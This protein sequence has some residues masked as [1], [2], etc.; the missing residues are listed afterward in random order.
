[1]TFSSATQRLS[2]S[3]D[4]VRQIRTPPD[5]AKLSLI[6][7]KRMSVVIGVGAGIVLFICI[8]VSIIMHRNDGDDD[9][10]VFVEDENQEQVGESKAIGRG[11]TFWEEL[12]RPPKAGTP[13][14]T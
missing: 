12:S 6:D 1:M 7:N 8:I 4:L 9:E 11:R 14:I 3:C 5:P 2:T 10:P 13:G